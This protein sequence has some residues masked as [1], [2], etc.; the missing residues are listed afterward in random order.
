MANFIQGQLNA[1][2]ERFAIVVSRFN[3]LITERLTTGAIDTITRLGVTLTPSTFIAS[4]VL[5]KSR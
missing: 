1:A 3:D 2:G 4:L 5:S